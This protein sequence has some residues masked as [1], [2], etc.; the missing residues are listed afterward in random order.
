MTEESQADNGGNQFWP[1]VVGA[2]L[3]LMIGVAFVQYGWW[4]LFIVVMTLLG[5]LV[6]RYTSASA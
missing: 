2:V 6:G 1:T 5:A 3:G 4:G